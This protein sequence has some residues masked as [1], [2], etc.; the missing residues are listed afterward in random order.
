MTPNEIAAD[1]A[2]RYGVT[3]DPAVVQILPARVPVIPDCYWCEKTQQLLNRE[4]GRET[5]RKQIQVQTDSAKA[6]RKQG[7]ERHRAALKAD[8]QHRVE[9]LRKFGATATLHQLAQRMGVLPH[10]AERYA[11]DN[12]IGYLGRPGPRQASKAELADRR[13][14]VLELHKAG[15]SAPKIS[16]ATGIPYRQVRRDLEAM[17]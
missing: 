11:K 2:R 6:A 10:T 8:K 9:A 14:K 15:L 13:V 5:F 3:V 12:N 7:A 16:E 17:L 4:N 1:V